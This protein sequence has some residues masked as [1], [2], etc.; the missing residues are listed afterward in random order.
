MAHRGVGVRVDEDVQVI[1][2]GNEVRCFRLEQTVAENVPGHVAN[3]GRRKGITLDVEA[4]LEEVTLH[5]NP[6]AAGGDAH[7]LVVIAVAAT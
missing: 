7:L 6:G 2:C 5:R 4:A 3:A 1:E